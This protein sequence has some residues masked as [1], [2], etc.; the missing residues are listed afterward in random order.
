M[1]LEYSGITTPSTPQR[2]TTIIPNEPRYNCF[3]SAP[4]TSYGDRDAANRV[5]A[6]ASSTRNLLHLAEPGSPRGF[7]PW[8]AAEV[9]P[10]KRARLMS[11]VDPPH[12]PHPGIPLPAPLPRSRPPRLP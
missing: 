10:S 6:Q 4:I 8:I 2:T 9:R 1:F 5:A 11:P 12:P 3:T 7:S